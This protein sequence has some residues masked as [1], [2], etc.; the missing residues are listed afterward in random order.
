MP[1][2][3]RFFFLFLHSSL[4]LLFSQQLVVCMCVPLCV[5]GTFVQLEKCPWSLNILYGPVKSLGLCAHLCTFLGVHVCVSLMLL[6][7]LHVLGDTDD[8]FICEYVTD[9]VYSPVSLVL[10]FLCLC[11]QFHVSPANELMWGGRTLRCYPVL[12]T[13]GCPAIERTGEEGRLLCQGAVPYAN[14]TTERSGGVGI[15]SETPKDKATSKP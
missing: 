10:L 6:R 5:G 15:S 13:L 9:F 2:Q 11:T 4:I 7:C 8:G 12:P 3:P 14:L 1:P